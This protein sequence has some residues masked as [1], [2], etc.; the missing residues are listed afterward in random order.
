MAIIIEAP[1]EV[2]S[3]KNHENIK[4]FLAG[5][6]T[7]CPDWQ[8]TIINNLIDEPN[9]TIYNPR[10]ADFPINDPNASEEQI[11]WEYN[12]LKE[13]DMIIYWFSKGS[14]NPI[15][16][17]ELGKWGTSIDKP[18]YI[19]IDKDYTRSVDVEI[20]TK[21]ANPH[22]KIVYSLDEL[23]EIVKEKLLIKTN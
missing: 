18:I 15:V 3:L 6:I 10:R 14:I 8:S 1:N 11:T 21:L 13:A 20:Q 4:L 9:L 7:D 16:L 12:H 5:G 19:G 22:T 2:Y 23:S 17:Y